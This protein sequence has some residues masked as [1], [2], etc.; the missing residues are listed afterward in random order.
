VTSAI[1]RARGRA[2][3]TLDVDGVRHYHAIHGFPAPDA[4]AIDP[5]IE[6]GVR[7]FLDLCDRFDVKATLF[8]VTRDLDGNDAFA[9]LLARAA[10]DGHEIASHSHAHAYD[11]S[12]HA[13]DAIRDDV[14]RSVQAIERVTGARPRGF[15]APGYNVSEA[16][17]D[18]LEDNGIAYD[19]S[20]MPSPLYWAARTLIIGARKYM[21]TPSSSIVGHARAF[22]DP[23]M[24]APYRPRKGAYAKRARSR[25]DGR[26]LVEVPIATLPFGVPW[27]GTTLGMAP[28]P[29]GATS[30]AAALTSSAPV[31]LELHA[32]DLCDADDG[33]SPHLARVQRELRVPLA[34][35]LARLESAVRMLAQARDVVTVAEIARTTA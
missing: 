31:V 19:S 21:G 2:A 12:R 9:A 10:H 34:R 22:V 13:P 30:T 4:R 11:M 28:L 33:F 35:K 16:L 15:R 18:A 29:V 7:R 25:V 24:R 23:R 20:I 26:N 17:L 27:L 8:V 3:V 6:L 1:V 5:C 14:A 32:I